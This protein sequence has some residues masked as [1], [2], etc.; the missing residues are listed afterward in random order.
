MELDVTGG[1]PQCQ[2]R[3][4]W[5]ISLDENVRSQR[6]CADRVEHLDAE[7]MITGDLKVVG[8]CELDG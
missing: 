8:A 4:L 5:M 7:Q 2:D 1:K 6:K 3:G